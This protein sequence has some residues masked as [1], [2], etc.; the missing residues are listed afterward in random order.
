M[1]RGRLDIINAILEIVSKNDSK[2]TKKTDIYRKG[3]LS[4]SQGNKYLSFL[5]R[6]NLLNIENH[7]GSVRYKA[8]ENGIKF[9]KG[10]KELNDLAS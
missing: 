1:R 2:G 8:S 6:V 7:D 5:E 3:N 9:L 10:Y 4:T